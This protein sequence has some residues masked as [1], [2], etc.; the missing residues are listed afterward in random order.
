[1]TKDWVLPE[2]R[3]ASEAHAL[4]TTAKH[5]VLTGLSGAGKSAVGSRL[6]NRLQ[7]DFCDLD[8]AI[9]ERAEMSIP[10]IFENAGEVQFRVMERELLLALLASERQ[11]VVATGAGA[12]VDTTNRKRALMAAHVVWLQVTPTNAAKRLAG[13]ND[14]PL[15]SRGDVE[16]R[17]QSMLEAREH[18]YAASHL[19]VDTNNQTS[20]WVA[21]TLALQIHEMG[22][23]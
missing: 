14:R 16:G 2:C 15:L 7:C 3:E 4:A 18:A 11:T 8:L 6:A 13:H 12:L 5:I 10:E 1:M 17:L 20:E 9:S 21:E 23:A 19:V 22:S